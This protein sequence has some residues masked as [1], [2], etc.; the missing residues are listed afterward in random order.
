[1]DYEMRFPGFVSSAGG[2]YAIASL[3]GITFSGYK[4]W[5]VKRL[6][7]LKYILSIYPFF[8]GLGV[9]FKELDLW[10]RND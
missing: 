4:A 1:M 9:W 7:D 10:T 2:K 6:I 3:Y 8:N 5:V